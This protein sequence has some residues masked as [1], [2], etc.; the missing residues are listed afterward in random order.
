MNAPAIPELLQDMERR[1][2]D[3]IDAIAADVSEVKA[4]N[5]VIIDAVS[6]LAVRFTRLETDMKEMQST[7]AKKLDKPNED[8]VERIRDGLQD[9]EKRASQLRGGISSPR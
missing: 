8:T 2:G 7:V 5:K 6:N 1:L 9:M 3:R 4:S